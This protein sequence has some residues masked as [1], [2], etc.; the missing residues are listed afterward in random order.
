[1]PRSSETV[2]ALASALAKAQAEL[3][4]PEKSL[5][6]TIRTG[7][8]GD[9]ERSFRYAPLSSGLDIVRKTLGQHEIATLQTTAI[10][11]AAGMVTLTTTLAHASGEWV[12]SDWP[13]C[14]VAETA[15]P[16]RMG[17]A[18]T[19]AR[20]YAL[21]TL[22]GIAGEDDLDAPD[23][24]D[25]PPSL[26]S[27]DDRSLKDSQLYM[28]ARPPGNGRVHSGRKGEIPVTLDPEQ[29]AA[30]REKLL[31]E[32]GNIASADLAAAWARQALAAKNTL[33]ATDAK[34]VEDTFER[35]ISELP[36]SDAAV[37]SNDD[38]SVPQV[39]GLQVIATAEG[40][41]L[42]QAKG[43]DKSI[44]TVAAPRR[45]RNREHLRYVAQ[46]A[47]LVCGR[48][49][50]DPHHLGFTQPRAL[51][52]KVSDEFA[53]PLCRGHHRAVH[54]SRNERAW[55]RQA[56]IDPIKVA[57][58]LWRETRGMGQRRSQR[59]ASSRSDVVAPSSDPRPENKDISAA[60]PPQ[61]ETPLPDL[62]GSQGPARLHARA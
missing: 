3:V 47:C 21:F 26:S 60:A 36:S 20:R 37:P 11:Q 46:Q 13:V 58:R 19:Y 18:L 5:T 57:R 4:N 62:P 15:N 6:A 16:Q 29:S 59:A 45:Y 12:A 31:T 43:I 9:S 44:L 35:R 1:M 33:T 48:K 56:G 40:T 55:W 38:S 22:V 50:S 61:E 30:L 25:G 28:P 7:R 42:G 17:A 2:A 27:A 41:D 49:P 14:P 51:G 52:R 53:V 24:C 34:L 39:A 32:V 8:P 23:L 10:D 54:R